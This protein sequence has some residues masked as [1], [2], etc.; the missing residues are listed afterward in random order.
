MWEAS[1]LLACELEYNWSINGLVKALGELNANVR[2][3]GFILCRKIFLF[4]F[5]GDIFMPRKI[6]NIFPKLNAENLNTKSAK[7]KQS[8]VNTLHKIT[9]VHI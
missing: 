8:H 2:N 1:V 4:Y 6:N 7:E 5:P 9:A 3:L